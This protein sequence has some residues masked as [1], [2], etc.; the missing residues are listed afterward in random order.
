M[1]PQYVLTQFVKI[2]NLF[3]IIPVDDVGNTSSL[4]PPLICS[5]YCR[6]K[7]FLIYQEQEPKFVSFQY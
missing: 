5:K 7:E 1:Y 2:Q 4:N 3:I 6:R